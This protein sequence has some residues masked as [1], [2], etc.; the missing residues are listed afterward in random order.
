MW[1]HNVWVCGKLTQEDFDEFFKRVA[2]GKD[3]ITPDDLRAALLTTG[4]G[5]FLP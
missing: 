3:H 1:D 2:K 4:S 5:G